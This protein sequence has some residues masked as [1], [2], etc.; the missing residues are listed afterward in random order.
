[1][2]LACL[3]QQMTP[4]EVLMGATTIAAR[5]VAAEQRIGSLLPGYEADIAIIDT[6]SLNHWL[7]HFRGNACSAVLKSGRWQ[8]QIG[9][10]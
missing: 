8:R 3:N 1:M 2:T 9:P 6:P 10:T 5:A 7:Y 4:Q